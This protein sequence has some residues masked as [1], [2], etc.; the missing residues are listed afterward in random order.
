MPQHNNTSKNNK[1]KEQTERKTSDYLKSI[2]THELN[3]SDTN[4]LVIYDDVEY[5]YDK[6]GQKISIIKGEVLNKEHKCCPHCSSNNIIGHGK[7][8]TRIKLLQMQGIYCELHLEK[9]RYKCKAC[10]KTFMDST[11]LVNKGCNISTIVIKKALLCLKEVRSIK[12]IAE[13]LN[14]SV[15][16]V[17][18]ILKQ[19]K[20]KRKFN[21]LPFVMSFDEFKSVKRVDASMSFLCID[22]VSNQII[23]I[24]PDRRIN[25][26][27]A[28]FFRYPLK[29]RK[30]VKYIVT[31]MYTPYIELIKS[32]FPN[33]KVVTDR[34]HLV[35]LVT[36]SFTKVRINIMKEKNKKCMEYKRMKRY[37]K[38]LLKASEELTSIHFYRYV[39]FKQFQSQRSVVENIL[40][41]N[42]DLKDC[43]EF[44]QNIRYMIKSNNI[45]SLRDI[46]SEESALPEVMETSKRTL[47]KY[48]DYIE[49]TLST[50]YNNGR[51]EGMI[52]KIKLLKRASYGYRSFDNLQKRIRLIFE[53]KGYTAPNLSDDKNVKSINKKYT[54]HKYAFA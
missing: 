28:Y 13:E 48:L 16:S 17:L 27:K 35:Q 39:H 36:R 12:S 32:L 30:K 47:N 10:S 3:N 52:C 20:V 7:K 29:V 18:R 8:T 37:W 6:K 43:Y 53:D 11:S 49:N 19:Y 33:A 51:I 45:D 5:R 22:G 1:I 24:L 38:L 46:L 14:I 31:D 23:D 44:M 40:D 54:G 42:Q 50:P 41:E 26:L 25:A 21:Y 2:I 9:H 34:F 15:H 4:N